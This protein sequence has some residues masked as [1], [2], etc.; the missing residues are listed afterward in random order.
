[1]KDLNNV[2]NWSELGKY[3]ANVDSKKQ[4]DFFK[5]ML[6]E[7]SLWGSLTDGEHQLVSINLELSPRERRRLSALT[8][9]EDE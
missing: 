3:F 6:Y 8:I 4:A 9:G 1:M 5:G 2:L 7:M